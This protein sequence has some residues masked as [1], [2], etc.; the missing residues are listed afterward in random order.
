MK[1]FGGSRELARRSLGLVGSSV[2]YVREMRKGTVPGPLLLIIRAANEMAHSLSQQ[3]SPTPTAAQRRALLA[4]GAQI[5][6]MTRSIITSAQGRDPRSLEAELAQLI[7]R[8]LDLIDQVTAEPAPLAENVPAI[9]VRDV[10]N[11]PKSISYKP[12]Q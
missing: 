11:E 8:T 9:L 6:A 7:T 1:P 5:R 3:Q 10:T 2:A 12:K 4:A